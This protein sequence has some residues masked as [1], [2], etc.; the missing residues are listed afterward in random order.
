MRGWIS[1]IFFLLLVSYYYGQNSSMST[2]PKTDR[3]KEF[4]SS[5]KKYE[6]KEEK[7]KDKRKVQDEQVKKEPVD[8]DVIRVN[9]ELVALD[10]LVTD[11]KGNIITGLKKEDFIVLEDGVPQKVEMFSFSENRTL[12]RSIVLVIDYLAAQAPYLKTSIEAAKS[13]VDKLRE[14]DQMAIATADLKLWT[15]FTKDKELLKRTLDS[16][17]ERRTEFWSGWEFRTLLAVI[18]EMFG[19]ENQQKIIIFQTY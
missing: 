12:P 8:E 5:L 13:L 10:V 3:V 6:K 17:R 14:N 19:E 9:T 18:N 1:I 11:Q 2:Q 7:K 4:G 15:D 16:I